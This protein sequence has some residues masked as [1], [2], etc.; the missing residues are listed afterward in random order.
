[1]P[2]AESPVDLVV[3]SEVRRA[4]RSGAARRVRELARISQG[5][6]SRT[7]GISAPTVSY[8]ESGSKDPSQRL[9]G[10]YVRFLCR[11]ARSLRESD[12][13]AVQE[14]LRTAELLERLGFGFD[15]AAGPKEVIPGR[16]A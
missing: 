1:M 14:L 13:S 2:V 15:Q 11:W 4:T 7:L 6:L 12:D 3:L 5:E 10:P 8:W 16:A 9:A